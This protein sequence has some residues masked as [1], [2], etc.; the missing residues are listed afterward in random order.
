MIL[1]DK[2]PKVIPAAIPTP[3][4]HAIDPKTYGKTIGLS[5]SAYSLI[6]E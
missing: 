6:L 2:Y 3:A 4:V 5:Y 1:S